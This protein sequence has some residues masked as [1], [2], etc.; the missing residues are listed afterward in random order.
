MKSALQSTRLRIAALPILTP[1][2]IREATA[3]LIGLWRRLMPK[4]NTSPVRALLHHQWMPKRST[5]NGARP[6]RHLNLAERRK[7]PHAAVDLGRLRQVQQRVL[8]TRCRLAANHQPFLSSPRERVTAHSLAFTWRCFD[9]APDAVEQRVFFHLQLEGRG[10]SHALRCDDLDNNIIRY[11][12]AAIHDVFD[13]Q[14][15]S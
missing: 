9:T 2:P 10:Y 8:R 13:S 6:S 15:R 14:V 3:C 11:E 7:D 5:G 4:A 12:F 1:A